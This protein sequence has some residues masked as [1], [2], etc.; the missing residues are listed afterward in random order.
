MHA[1]RRSM[2]VLAWGLAFE[3]VAASAWMVANAVSVRSQTTP[4][5][6]LFPTYGQ[7]LFVIILTIL[8]IILG[9]GFFRHRKWGLYGSLVLGFLTNVPLAGIAGSFLRGP[10][11]KIGVVCIIFVMLFAASAI[12]ALK[13]RGLFA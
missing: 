3:W 4:G 7:C 5:T 13:N 2:S 6:T 9:Y 1:R 10:G 12:V 8:A 11:W